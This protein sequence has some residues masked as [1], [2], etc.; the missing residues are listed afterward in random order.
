MGGTKSSGSGFAA[1]ECSCLFGVWRRSRKS[2]RKSHRRSTYESFRNSLSTLST[3][4]EVEEEDWCEAMEGLFEWVGMAGLGATR[5][6]DSL[7]FLGH[8]ILTPKT[9]RLKANDRIDPFVAV[10]EPPSSTRIGNVTHL[11]WTG[12]IGPSFV[13]SLIDLLSYVPFLPPSLEI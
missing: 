6:E 13:Q 5:Q 8:K 10:Y 1:M 12:F 3:K 9:V 4:Q 7:L 2:F 11:R